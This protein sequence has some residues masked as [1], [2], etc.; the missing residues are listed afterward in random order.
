MYILF[1]QEEIT[2]LCEQYSQI[3]NNPI[4]N[5]SSMEKLY[6]NM[7]QVWDNKVSVISLF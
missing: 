6:L 2:L 1:L 3:I 7:T 4:S 5:R